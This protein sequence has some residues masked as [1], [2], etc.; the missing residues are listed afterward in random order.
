MD[1]NKKNPKNEGRTELN[2]RFCVVYALLEEAGKISSHSREEG[3][4]N[5]RRLA[6]KLLGSKQQG[7]II[8][9]YLKG[10]RQIKYEE[11]KV[12]C[13]IFRE[14][15]RE[16]LLDGIGEP[17]LTATRNKADTATAAPHGRGR[18]TFASAEAHASSAQDV[19]LDQESCEYFQ[20]PGLHGEFIAFTVRGN[21]MSP[22]IKQSDIVICRALHSG[23]TI[24]DNEIYAVSVN[25]A[26]MVKRLQCIWDKS[27][28]N[29]VKIKLISDNYIE[30][31]P[32]VEAATNIQKYWKVEKLITSIA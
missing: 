25:G 13:T 23:E 4:F 24:K 5:N 21:S 19:Q 29:V 30:H 16:Y 9:D 20:I 17:L 18:I 28:R 14:I 7:H 11:A 12:L 26:I 22:N 27:R 31:D 2:K 1:D 32:I 3:V 15:N 8:A 10:S 6:E